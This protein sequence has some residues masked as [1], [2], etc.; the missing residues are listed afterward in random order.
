MYIDYYNCYHNY[1]YLSMVFYV[2]L[3][4]FTELLNLRA[5]KKN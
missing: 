1:F 3:F 4:I 5:E 2:L